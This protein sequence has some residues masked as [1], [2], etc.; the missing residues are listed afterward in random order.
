MLSLASNPYDPFEEYDLWKKFDT[1]EG[2][3]TPGFLARAV[4]TSEALSEPDQD[5]AVEQAIESILA[6]V[7]FDGLYKKVERKSP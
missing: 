2:Y 5:L 1:S 3:D 7:H 6:N 4:S